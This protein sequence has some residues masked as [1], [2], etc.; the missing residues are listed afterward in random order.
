MADKAINREIGLIKTW[1]KEP[2]KDNEEEK[3]VDV[4]MATWNENGLIPLIIDRVEKSVPNTTFL[5]NIFIDFLYHISVPQDG[6]DFVKDKM[7]VLT[8]IYAA[9]I[10]LPR[11]YNGE[12]RICFADFNFAFDS[13]YEL[14]AKI[15]KLLDHMTQHITSIKKMVKELSNQLVNAQT[16][17]E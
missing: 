12:N 15:P 8:S 3:K 16:R 14:T 17:I 6:V 4:E 11:I 5:Y 7:S 2:E 1:L 13:H 10:E 9:K